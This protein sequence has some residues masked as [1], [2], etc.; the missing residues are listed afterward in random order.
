[1]SV[2]S[3]TITLQTRGNGDI[4]NVSPEVERIVSE[5][6]DI[7]DGFVVVFIGGATGAITT[8][9]YESGL[10]RDLKEALERIA[11]RDMHYY[12]NDKWHDD[13][14]HAHVRASLIGPSVTIPLVGGKMAL[15][16]WQQIVFIDFDNR[17][18]TRH[19]TVQVVGE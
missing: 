6:R 2:A 8:V 19:I 17:P 16:T 10:L 4:L 11:P 7:R 5:H 14:G 3:G 15:G 13:N 12:H 18:R 1:M 9:E